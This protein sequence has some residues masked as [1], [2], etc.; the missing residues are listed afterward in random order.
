MP[1]AVGSSRLVVPRTWS[2]RTGVITRLWS[3]L[4]GHLR[5]FLSRARLVPRNLPG[6]VHP[7]HQ[8]ACRARAALLQGAR[9]ICGAQTHRGRSAK[10]LESSIGL[11][12]GEDPDPFRAAAPEA[13]HGAGAGAR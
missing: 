9:A 6:Q 2:T 10:S 5:S 7:C 1:G 12:R 4:W 11:V 8:D 3:L 13:R